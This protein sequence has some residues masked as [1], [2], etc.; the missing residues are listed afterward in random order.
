MFIGLVI[1]SDRVLAFLN[2]AKMQAIQE[3]RAAKEILSGDVGR[4]LRII[5]GHG[6]APAMIHVS[7]I[8]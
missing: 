6:C 8:R 7:S 3:I 1:S 4:G 2:L 5:D